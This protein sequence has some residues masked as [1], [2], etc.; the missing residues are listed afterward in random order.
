MSLYLKRLEA[1]KLIGVAL[2]IRG[3]GGV[4]LTGAGDRFI[5]RVHKAL[6]QLIDTCF[7]K[8]KLDC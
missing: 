2:F 5:G 1:G 3:H 4:S 6:N 7:R 8:S